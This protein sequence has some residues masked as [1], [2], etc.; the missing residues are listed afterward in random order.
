MKTDL[1]DGGSIYF[2][3]KEGKFFGVPKGKSKSVVNTSNV[4]VQELGTATISHGSGGDSGVVVITVSDSSTYP[5]GTH[6]D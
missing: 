4:S 1:Q 6:W 2:K 3:N 5:T